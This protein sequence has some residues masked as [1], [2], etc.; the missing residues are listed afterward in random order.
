MMGDMGR[1][2]M[3]IGGLLFLVGLLLTF[4]GR[5]PGLG[6]LP[7]DFVFQRGHVTVYFPLGTMIVL[8]LLL[9]LVL[10]LAGRLLR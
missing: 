2:L 4:A 1:M 8:S 6:R 5:L 7:G 10:N 3:L 9:T